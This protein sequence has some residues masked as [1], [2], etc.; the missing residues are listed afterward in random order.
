[1]KKEKL[2]VGAGGLSA[3]VHKTDDVW[4]M[5]MTITDTK[6]NEEQLLFRTLKE[7]KKFFEDINRKMQGL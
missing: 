7:A 3:R 1:M 4:F 2:F 6:I 5:Y